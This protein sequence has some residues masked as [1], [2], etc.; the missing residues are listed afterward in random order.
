MLSSYMITEQNARS[1]RTER[2]LSETC[3]RWSNRTCV[4]RAKKKLFFYRKVYTLEKKIR[5]CSSELFETHHSVCATTKLRALD[6]TCLSSIIYV[7]K[8]RDL[9]QTIASF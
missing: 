3:T 6:R 5:I 8:K 9:D 4:A 1:T 2:E 7:Q